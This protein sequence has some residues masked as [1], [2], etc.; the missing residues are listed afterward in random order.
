V[1]LPDVTDFTGL[2]REYANE[3][4][5]EGD[6]AADPFVQFRAWFEQAE[7]AGVREP[8]A[9]SLATVSGDGRPSVR[10]VLLKGVDER[11]FSFFTDYR[12]R[13][14]SELDA[15]R[16]AALCFHWHDVERQVRVGGTVERVSAEES[17]AYFASRPRGSQLGAWS[18]HQSSPL[19]AR[20]TLERAV[21]ANAE[22]FVNGAVPLPPHW[23]GYRVRPDEIEF[24]QGRANRL[25]D[26]ILYTRSSASWKISRLSP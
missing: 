23:G 24:W 2:R 1:Y 26:R 7:R 19:D 14:G 3:P 25:H 10:I 9:M 17:V 21:A 13:K 11:G 8:N 18:S 20:G 16:R 12:S 15:T 22:R 5:N 6:V 4:L